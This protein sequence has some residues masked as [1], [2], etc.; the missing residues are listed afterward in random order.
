MGHPIVTKGRVSNASFLLGT[1]LPGVKFGVY[2]TDIG[3]QSQSATGKRSE[4]GREY[5]F[6]F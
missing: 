6:V 3:R 1:V 5:T 2:F 4:F